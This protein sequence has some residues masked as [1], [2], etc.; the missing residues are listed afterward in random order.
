MT[1]E[2]KEQ[3]E[4]MQNRGAEYFYKGLFYKI[5]GY[6]TYYWND[7]WIASR[8]PPEELKAKHTLSKAIKQWDNI[9]G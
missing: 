4:A 9:D 2:L 6:E 3:F 8:L 5:Q 7:Q 1:K